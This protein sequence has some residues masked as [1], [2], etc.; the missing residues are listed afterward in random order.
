LISKEVAQYKEEQHRLE[1][2]V[3]TPLS[4]PTLP[5]RYF[6]HSLTFRQSVFNGQPIDEKAAQQLPAYIEEDETEDKTNSLEE[7]LQMRDLKI[8][9]GQ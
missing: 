8:G 5:R 1:K 7:E 6:N 2:G 4:L 9:E 3:E